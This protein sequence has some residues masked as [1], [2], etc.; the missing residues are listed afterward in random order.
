MADHSVSA[1]DELQES[2]ASFVLDNNKFAVIIVGLYE[3]SE[4]R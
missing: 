4:S 1:R 3:K 2:E